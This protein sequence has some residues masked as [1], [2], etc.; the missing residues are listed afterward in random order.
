M[1]EKRT[2]IKKYVTTQKTLRLYLRAFGTPVYGIY[3]NFI[4]MK[5]QEY[6]KDSIDIKDYNKFK[7]QVWSAIDNQLEKMTKN[8]KNSNS[9]PQIDI[10][11]FIASKKGEDN[12]A[13]RASV[14]PYNALLTNPRMIN[15]Y[16]STKFM[17]KKPGE[18]IERIAIMSS[19]IKPLEWPEKEPKE[20]EY[21]FQAKSRTKNTTASK[22]TTL[23]KK[24]KV[25]KPVKLQSKIDQVENNQLNDDI[26]IVEKRV[27]K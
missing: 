18:T 26:E 8:S 12:Y 17:F 14:V 4:L 23:E 1:T 16:Y 13:E 25:K 21:N 19:T 6:L 10:I 7:N 9:F 15:Y 5:D 3:G 27:Y 2:Q 22:K 11:F 24:T 20:I